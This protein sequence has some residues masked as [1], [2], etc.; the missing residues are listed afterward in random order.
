MRTPRRRVGKRGGMA[1]GRIGMGAEA[2]APRRAGRRPTFVSARAARRVVRI[3][4]SIIGCGRPRVNSS[5]PRSMMRSARAPLAPSAPAPGTARWRRRCGRRRAGSAAPPRTA[6]RRRRGRG[7]RRG[8]ARRLSAASRARPMARRARPPQR[9][10]AVA[11]RALAG[12][13]RSAGADEADRERLAAPADALEHGAARPRGRR[14]GDQDDRRVA[15]SASSRSIAA[16]VE[17]R[18][19]RGER[20]RPPTPM[21]C[22]MPRRPCAIRQ[23]D[24]LHAGAG[25]ADDADVAARHALAKASGTPPMMAVP[26]SGPITRRPS[27]LASRLSATSSRQR[28]V[29]GE[30][31][32]VETAPQRLARLGRGEVAGH[33]DQRQ[34]G[35]RQLPQRGAQLRGCR[36]PAPLGRGARLVEQRPRAAQGCSRRLRD[37]ARTRDDQVVGRGR[38]AFGFEQARVA[39]DVLVGGRAIISAGLLDAG[40]RGDPARERASARPSRG[41]S[42]ADL[43]A[44]AS[45]HA[46]PLLGR[47]RPRG[48]LEA[49][50]RRAHDARADLADARLAVG[51]AGVDGRRDAGLDHRRTSMP[52]A[53]RRSRAPGSSIPD[54]RRR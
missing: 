44:D 28:H 33:R 17:S 22:E 7:W 6:C 40:Q 42:P 36:A 20:S 27:A 10:A 2:D 19:P 46:A 34:V 48:L 1:A 31:H 15:G 29:V 32:D 35:V 13:C 38:L 9:P 23:R 43:V 52:V 54:S 8:L 41:R 45:A 11:A 3:V 14:L 12:S 24:F 51:D 18:R 21:A 50:E 30:D 5:A 47:Q 16:S 39:Q 49:R 26:Q 25:G 37:P 4:G 53:R